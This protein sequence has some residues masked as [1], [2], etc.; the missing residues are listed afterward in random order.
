[1]STVSRSVQVRRPSRDAD[2][3]IIEA[4]QRVGPRN[5]ALLSR[6]TGLHAETIRYKL[7][8]SYRRS[9]LRIHAGVDYER[10]GLRL[11]W[12]NL[13]FESPYSQ[14]AVGLLH[15][16]GEVGH[17][18]YYGRVIPKGHF[19]VLLALPEGGM[20]EYEALFGR[21][22]ERGMLKHYSTAGSP[23]SFHYSMNPKYFNFQSMSWEVDWETVAR[24]KP[25]APSGSTKD[26]PTAV[27]LYDLLII[28]ELQKDAQ[29][30]LVSVA[31]KLQ[32]NSKTLMY[33]YDNH[34]RSWG[35]IRDYEVRWMQDIEK[36]LAHSVLAT[37]ITVPVEDEEAEETVRSTFSKIPFIW[38][39]YTLSD[40]IYSAWL[41]VPL[42][43]LAATMDYLAKS[44]PDRSDSIEVSS[45]KGHDAFFFT[46]PYHTYHHGWKVDI[47]RVEARLLPGGIPQKR[48]VGKRSARPPA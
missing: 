25:R 19:A 24:D 46:I 5:V 14:S 38:T 8:S 41:N 37:N 9:G 30:H 26:A 12:C 15:K 16:M 31:K 11:V 36:S 2:A 33:H 32:V 18:V 1:L 35:L 47:R 22:K 40:G 21:M 44:L 10:L 28:K 29:Q 7:K 23:R 6:M 4:V 27:D 34:V 48:G 43:D 13:T 3:A 17:L 45:I 20:N 39:D 42:A